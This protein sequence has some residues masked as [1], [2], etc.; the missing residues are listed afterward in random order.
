MSRD[1]ERPYE[2][3]FDDPKRRG[4]VARHF[5]RLKHV[6]V[7]VGYILQFRVARIVS[8]KR[9][10]E[11]ITVAGLNESEGDLMPTLVF[12]LLVVE[13]VRH[14]FG[15]FDEHVRFEKID[16][17]SR[18]VE[19]LNSVIRPD[20]ARRRVLEERYHG[21]VAAAPQAAA[22]SRYSAHHRKVVRR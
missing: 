20:P 12:I 11:R 8:W 10:E 1:P 16:V 6:A 4:S 21:I 13:L 7:G 18:D 17:P 3:L 19:S 14:S 22:Q 15:S 9:V 5:L 2:M